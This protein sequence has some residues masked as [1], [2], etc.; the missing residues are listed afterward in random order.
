MAMNKQDYSKPTI[1]C[2]PKGV[3]HSD[4]CP[5]TAFVKAT[6]T[7]KASQQKCIRAICGVE[8]VR[9]EWLALN[10]ILLK[11]ALETIADKFQEQSHTDS[12]NNATGNI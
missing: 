6:K 11:E 3:N 9:Y 7:L 12:T 8:D 2:G 4:Y 5:L 10:I 1:F